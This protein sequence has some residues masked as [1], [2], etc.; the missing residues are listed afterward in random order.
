[1]FRVCVGVRGKF[2]GVDSLLL[3]R[4]SWELNSGVRFGREC[5]YPGGHPS[6]LYKRVFIQTSEFQCPLL[7]FKVQSK[8]IHRNTDVEPGNSLIDN[9]WLVQPSMW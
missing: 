6:S 9:H 4:G 3:Q 1:M 7:L 5:P 2:M 8:L